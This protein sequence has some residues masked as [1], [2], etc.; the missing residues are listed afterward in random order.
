MANLLVL[1]VANV[2]SKFSLFL[3]ILTMIGSVNAEPNLSTN[4]VQQPSPSSNAIVSVS[5]HDANVPVYSTITAAINAI[6]LEREGVWTISISPGHYNERVVINKPFVH[7]QGQGEQSTHISFNRYAGQLVS[8]DSDETWGTGRTAS[9]EINASNVTLSNLSISNSFDYPANELLEPNSPT[10]LKGTQAVALKINDDTDFIFLHNVSLWGYQ[11]T[12]Y[13]RGNRTYMLGG[14][15]AG[16]VDFIFGGGTA[17]F[18]SVDIIS[19]KKHDYGDFAGYITAPS[20]LNTRPFGLTFLGCKL[21]RE[22]GVLA[23][24]IALGRPWH[25]TTTFAD[26]R[27]ANPFAEGKTTFLMTYMDEHIAPL[28]WTTMSGKSIDGTRI[29]FDPLTQARFAEFASYGPGATATPSRPQLT[30]QE[31]SF[32]TKQAILAGWN[33]LAELEASGR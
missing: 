10:K 13:V 15:I 33:P 24:S 8:D 18:E 9:V 1:K 31:A 20:T 26:G 2:Q 11:D 23:N 3:L 6:P 12:L 4:V 30:E 25:P 16:H 28:G 7:L 21:L 5:G 27:Y 32:Y 29:Q 17:L 22:D 19:R 14:S